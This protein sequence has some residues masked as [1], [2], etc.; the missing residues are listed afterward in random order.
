MKIN[1][2][3]L[4]KLLVCVSHS[5]NDKK[6]EGLISGWDSKTIEDYEK[7]N[8]KRILSSKYNQYYIIPDKQYIIFDTDDE[9]SYLLLNNFLEDNKIL[10]ETAITKSYSGK[11]HNLYY[12]RH[13]WFKVSDVNEFKNIN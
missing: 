13:F 1:E 11:I 8:S 9:H 6:V 4:R 5:G 7:Y 2:L 3:N 12:K 10:I